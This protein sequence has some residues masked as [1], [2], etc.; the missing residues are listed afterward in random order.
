MVLWLFSGSYGEWRIYYLYPIP[1][2]PL[3][4]LTLLKWIENPY[5]FY[6]ILLEFN[7]KNR[8]NLWW[9]IADYGK[10]NPTSGFYS[11]LLATAF[12][13]KFLPDTPIRLRR[14]S[15]INF[16]PLPV[17]QQFHF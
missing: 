15:F 4:Y 6:V 17:A 12:K 16:L 10:F 13:W 8:V 5:K 9:M 2:K 14:G 7:E 1:K 11:P 3:F